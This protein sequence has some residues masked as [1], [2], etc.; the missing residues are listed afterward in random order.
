LSG[1]EPFLAVK[2]QIAIMLAILSSTVFS[3]FLIIKLQTRRFFNR[4]DQLVDF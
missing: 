1:A 2:Y 3:S 4:H